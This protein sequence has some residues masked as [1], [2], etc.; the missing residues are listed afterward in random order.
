MSA[1][2]IPDLVLIYSYHVFNV[3][4]TVSVQGQYN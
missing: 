1:E 4:P 3:F 2:D